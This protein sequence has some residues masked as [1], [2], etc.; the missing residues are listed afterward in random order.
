MIPKIGPITAKNLIAYVGS[1]E[2]IFAEKESILKKIPG[3]GPILAKYIKKPEIFKNAQDE[4]EFVKRYNIKTL[5]YLDENYP[6]RLKECVD[7]PILLYY[8]GDTDFNTKKMISIVGTRKS[9]PYGK[10]VCENIVK[11]LAEKK[12]NPII[13]SGLAFGIDICAHR[14]A[15]KNGLQ[16]IAILGHGLDIIY[17]AVHKATAIDIINNGALVT[18]FGRNSIRDKKNFVRRNRIIA[19]LTDATIVIESAVKGGALITAD[20]ANSYNREVFAVPGNIK[21]TYSMGCNKLIKINKAALI[22][23]SDDIE[24]LLGWEIPVNKTVRQQKELIPD[25]T[26]G[27]QKIIDLLK[28]DKTLNIDIISLKSGLTISESSALL[29]ELEFKNLIK[30]LPGKIYKLND[31]YYN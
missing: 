13:V 31:H 4:L 18:E 22:E 15:L 17:P 23:T 28:T 8:K 20:I 11:S 21:N 10:E 2:G 27:E 5:F 12:H 30:S 7:A 26:S 29:L 24:Y 14:A 9:T 19:G 25:L 3:V 1:Y 6:N 16:T